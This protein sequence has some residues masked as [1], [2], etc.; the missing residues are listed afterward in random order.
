M[1]FSFGGNTSSPSFSFG[2]AS[3][4]AASSPFASAA[5][6]GGGLFGSQNTSTGFGG[7]ASQPAFGAGSS[8]AGFNFSSP[9]T[10]STPAA[11]KPGLFGAASTPSMFGNAGKSPGGFSFSPASTQGFQNA[12]G[13]AGF[14]SAQN[15]QTAGGSMQLLTKDN[16]PIAHSSK[17]DDLS[18]Q[19]QQYLLELECVDMRFT[20][21]Y[22]EMVVIHIDTDCSV[23]LM[24]A[25]KPLTSIVKSVNSS[26]I[27]I[28]LSRVM[29]RPWTLHN[30]QKSSRKTFLLSLCE[31]TSTRMKSRV[32]DRLL[33][34]SFGTPKPLYIPIKER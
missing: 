19:A 31:K 10:F 20:S 33:F 2:G 29:M 4:A 1:A 28:T 32:F 16:R 34:I 9:S 13:V 11:S 21:F 15:Q 23:V 26:R 8:G 17:W 3:S 12:G 27:R 7:A 14:G 6:T 30:R 18:P 5:P 22:T 24:R 25:G